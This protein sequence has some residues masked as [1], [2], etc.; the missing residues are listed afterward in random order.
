MIKIQSGWVI[1]NQDL[2]LW[3]KIGGVAASSHNFQRD[4]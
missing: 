3:K 4:S 2:D 1:I